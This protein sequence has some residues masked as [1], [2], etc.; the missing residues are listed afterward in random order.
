MDKYRVWKGNENDRIE[1]TNGVFHAD[2]L[3]QFESMEE[4]V[5][6]LSKEY[7]K[8]FVLEHE[9]TEFHWS[10]DSVWILFPC[11]IICSEN[12]RLMALIDND[13]I[14][15]DLDRGIERVTEEQWEKLCEMC[16]RSEWLQIE[17]M[18]E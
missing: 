11:E 13:I 9:D 2:K 7:L 17:R 4:A 12:D 1:L 6:T 18:R 10:E 8:D 5:D 16:E 3:P 14:E 15:D